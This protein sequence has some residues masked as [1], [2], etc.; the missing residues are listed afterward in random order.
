MVKY[1][2]RHRQVARLSFQSSD[3]VKATQFEIVTGHSWSE[4]RL[5]M[6]RLKMGLS[7][8]CTVDAI[9]V[10]TLNF[11]VAIDK[12]IKRFKFF[13]LLVGIKPFLL[14]NIG[15]P[16]N[17]ALGSLLELEDYISTKTRPKK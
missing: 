16:T 3:F 7:Q 6:K 1:R 14:V 12:R 9:N 2:G 11:L 8:F 5:K 4:V 10:Q 17:A 13:K 15:Q